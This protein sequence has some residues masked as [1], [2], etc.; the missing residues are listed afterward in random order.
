MLS[1]AALAVV[2]VAED[3]PIDSGL[4]VLPRHLGH[5]TVAA[6]VLVLDGV[7]LVV[8]GVDGRDKEVVG[9]VLQVT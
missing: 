6:G 8:L 3:N 2:L 9:D 5:A 7:H 4:L 1:G